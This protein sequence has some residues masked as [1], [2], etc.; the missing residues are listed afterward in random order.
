MASHSGFRHPPP[1]DC[2][3]AI[4]IGAG[5]SGIN[6][7]YR[8]QTRCSWAK[9]LILESRNALGGTWDLFRY[10]GVRADSNI[11]TYGFRWH[12]WTRNNV[13][14]P[15]AADIVSYMSEAGSLSGVN[16]HIR[17]GH[18]VISVNWSSKEKTWALSVKVN[19][20]EKQFETRFII[21]AAG[22]YNHEKP[23]PA[24]IPGIENFQGQIVHP[25]SWP[26]DLD[27]EGKNIVLI[28]SGATAV[29][30]FPT[31]AKKAGSVTLLQRSPAYIMPTKNILRRSWY[32]SFLWIWLADFL[33]RTKSI[34]MNNY[35]Y[36]YCQSQPI[37]AARDIQNA[38]I[39]YLPD[40]YP[41]DP[42]LTP[43]YGPWDLRPCM[44]PD[45]D[46]FTALHADNAHIV[47]DSIKIVSE[48]GIIL[49][50]GRNLEADIIITATGLNL[51][52]FGGAEISMDGAKVDVGKK[53]LWKLMMV[54][55]IPNMSVLLG[56]TNQAWMLGA[57]LS[58]S[59]T[60]RHLNYM[61][62]NGLSVVVPRLQKLSQMKAS[63]AFFMKATYMMEGK[64][65]MPKTGS[66][67]PWLP[68]IYYVYDWFSA[69]FLGIRRDLEFS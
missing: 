2:F 1:E 47:T 40:Q 64:D 29:T 45:G 28:G 26:E 30:V 68:R 10:P 31:L 19:G 46:F 50:S 23:L 43:R 33:E 42:H 61:N 41:Y 58:A 65:R 14:Y 37:Q 69:T 3:D 38:A 53:F 63:P 44:A 39:K 21:S 20:I 11:L 25:Q 24:M 55:D 9:Y 15:Q 18:K 54:Q 16:E 27:Y 52:F 8:I 22:Y 57:D 6:A 12:T 66:S 35:E 60:C 62:Q 59:I 5:L 67:E 7:A 56:Y 13:R 32:Y 48:T 51:Q 34:V 36:Y 17:Y 4:I 49:Q